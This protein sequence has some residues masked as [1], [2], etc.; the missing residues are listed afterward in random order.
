M[1]AVLTLIWLTAI[2]G[3]EVRSAEQPPAGSPPGEERITVSYVSLRNRTGSS[4]AEDF[5]GG[6]RDKIR[7][8]TCEVAFAPIWGLE[9]LAQSAPFYI[10]D[11]KSE[12][13]AIKEK[14]VV[15]FWSAFDA[16][17]GEQGNIIVY[18]HGYKVDFGKSCRRAAIFQRALGLQDRLLLIT[19]PADG[20]ML[21][22]TWD[23]ADLV[24]SVPHITRILKRVVQRFGQDRVNIVA[25]SLGAR[26]AMQA[27]V[28]MACPR[29][30][31]PLINELIL[32]APDIDT[33]IFRQELSG[34]RQLVQR[35]TVYVSEN[36]KALGLSQDV[37]GYPRLGQAGDHL[38][39]FDSVE[40]I[41]LSD[42]GKRRFSGH[43]YH[44]FNPAIIA[45][46]TRLIHTG[47]AAGQRPDLE[48]SMHKGLPFWRMVP[49][50]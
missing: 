7:T 17:G 12:L 23:E 22:Y 38:A 32:L 15:Q 43:L 20:N 2:S 31:A 34:F 37:H 41:D 4:S 19:W 45:D 21:K 36:D 29:P 1:L 25:H 28:N 47:E 6:T 9:D 10:P 42:I 33:D 27:L 46:L 5:Y 44:L 26:G 49:S 30:A 48:R 16:A 40:T 18:I 24:W 50:E 3:G 13:G 14:S 35:I 11:E 8:G 39:V